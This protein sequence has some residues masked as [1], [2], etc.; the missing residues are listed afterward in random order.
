MTGF[1]QFPECLACNCD[2]S[3]SVG[4]SCNADGQCN[5]L[6][7]FDG[8]TCNSC[9][10]SFYNYPLCESCDC[11]PAGVIAKFAGCGSVPAGELCQC[12]ERV[13]G[14]ICDQC[15]PLYWNLNASNPDGCEE[16]DCF[17]DGTIGTLDTCEIKSGQCSCKQNVQGRRCNECTD[18]TFD[19]FGASLYGCKPCDC[20]IGGA[21][22]GICHKNT[23]ECRCHPRITGRDCTRPLQLHYFPT[24]Y[25][26]KYEY[27][28]G[29]T[30]T[31]AQVRY[32]FDEEVFPDFSK[33]GY[34]V[35]SQLQSEVTNDVYIQKSSFYQLIIR[36][37]NPTEEPIVADILIQ[38]ENTANPDQEAK[39]L[40]KPNRQPEFVTMSGT[41]GDIPSPIVL[42][43]GKYS[44]VIKSNQNLFLDYFVLLPAA[45]YEASILTRK[46]VNPCKVDSESDLCRMYKYPSIEEFSPISKAHTN[47]NDGSYAAA[48]FY[49]N[50]EHLS[51]INEQEFPLLTPSQSELNYVL[52]V[53]RPG[54]YILVIDYITDASYTDADF[55]QVNQ[56]SESE[57]D[58]IV[59]IYPCQYQMVCRG[60][61]MDKESREKVFF[62]D[63]NDT[64]PVIISSDNA[65]GIAIKS[66]TP[67]PAEQWSS[68]FIQPQPVCISKNG[69]CVE[70][71]FSAAPDS[72][73]IEFESEQEERIA[74]ENLPDIFS[75]NTKV[76]YLNKDSQS[77]LVSSKV[78]EPGRYVILVKY[79]QP[80]HPK[81]NI[82]YRL[83]T[84]RQNYDGKFS[85]DH[86]PSSSGCRGSITPS[87][88][89][90]WFEID[91][92]FTF[93]LTNMQ[94]K[95]VW[96]DY[97][98]LV[99][100][101]YFNERLLVEE[102]FD[103]T[104][105]FLKECGQDHFNVQLNASEFCKSSVFSLTAEYNVGALPCGC[106]IDG[107]TSFECEQFGGQCQ[108][109]PNIIGRQCEA[110][111]TGFYGFPDC[112]PCDCPSTA[113]CEKRT[114]ECICPPRV[115]GEKCDQCVPYTFGFDQI[116]GCEDCNCNEQGVKYGNLQCDLNNG[117][118]VCGS[119]VVGRSCDKCAYGFFNFP[120]CERKF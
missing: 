52:H 82:I 36:Y 73:K 53:N 26:F 46:V 68:D 59:L 61:V 102:E 7:S 64:H 32:Q 24:L 77:V 8:K 99:P 71:K 18:G 107:S 3:G 65:Q 34:A 113:I 38:S 11:N 41:K 15:R 49:R 20:D 43:P 114:G 84:D 33:I 90:P 55:L 48:E 89:Y 29:F 16:C 47:R 12:K 54:R 31:G 62:I 72:K 93:S 45:Y 80:N 85:L 100:Y 30:S 39:V 56:E 101:E 60:P 74:V 40:F 103:Q 69:V 58:G 106:D 119:N 110:C 63:V 70:S 92:S 35:F 6:N 57:Q 50:Y 87:E 78:S 75:N 109:K 108:C 1:Y 25:Q 37:K 19:L 67:I 9:K 2:T 111:K 21:A 117:S 81:F 10:E 79:Y 94:D 86:C 42:D 118:C 28:D 76:I 44:I 23:G 98:I 51:K 105:E 104:V 112:K 4:I 83:E 115:T 88:G 5:C 96:L 17:T 95:G 27:E 120:Y 14:R 91:D 66:V 97:V 22:S 116:I 13:Q